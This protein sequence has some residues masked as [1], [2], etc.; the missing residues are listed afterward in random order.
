MINM[1]SFDS[2]D[3]VRWNKVL[4]FYEIGKVLSGDYSNHDVFISSDGSTILHR[5]IDE[6]G[7]DSQEIV[8]IARKNS[9]VD[10]VE[11]SMLHKTATDMMKILE[12]YDVFVDL[13]AEYTKGSPF[14]RMLKKRTY[15]IEGYFN[16]IKNYRPVIRDIDSMNGKIPEM[17][18][19]LKKPSIDSIF[20]VQFCVPFTEEGG[21]MVSDVKEKILPTF[22]ELDKFSAENLVASQKI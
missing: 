12:K 7:D 18:S 6:E 14:N 16:D 15:S 2:R 22:S 3:G 10:S 9:T 21:D 20:F 5:Y 8:K 11:Y 13:C 1:S 17:F 19:K 4:D